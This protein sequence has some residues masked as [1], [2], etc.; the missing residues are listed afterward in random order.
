MTSTRV[1]WLTEDH[2]RT[3]LR[4]PNGALC[5][6]KTPAHA[7]LFTDAFEGAEGRRSC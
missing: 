1:N 3:H 6:A 7:D 4:S 5:F 2:G